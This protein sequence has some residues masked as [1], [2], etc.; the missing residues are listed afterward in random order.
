MKKILL[1]FF[2]FASYFVVAQPRSNYKCIY[3]LDI[4]SDTIKGEYMRKE[5]YVVQIG[6]NVTKGF[7]Y[8]KFYNDSLAKNNPKLYHKLRRLDNER[9]FDEMPGKSRE[10]FVRDAMNTPFNDGGFSSVVYKDRA[11]NEM[12]VTDVI[13]AINNIDIYYEDSIA[14]QNWQILGDTTTILGYQCQKAI[15]DY[16]GRHF[17][18]W[19]TTEIPISEGPYKFWGLPG[20]I[21]RLHDSEKHY[22]FELLGF[23]QTQE[24]IEFEITKEMRK[25]DR[26]KFLN[27][28]HGDEKDKIS[29]MQFGDTELNLQRSEPYIATY[30]NIERDYK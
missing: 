29:K 8:Q 14:P 3:Q 2:L 12:I 25:V 16:R 21:T 15:C 5:L 4:L 7:T 18:A 20:L 30:D 23:H 27:I 19:F 22:N 17:I 6:D 1:I 24:P 26:I 28:N 13:L 11:Q 9:L 10:Q